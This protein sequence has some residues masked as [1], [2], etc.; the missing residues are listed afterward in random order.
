[1]R[2]AVHWLQ[3]FFTTPLPSEVLLVE[4]L[5]ET[6]TEAVL[7]TDTNPD[8]LWHDTVIVAEIIQAEQHP[9]ADSLRVCRVN[10]G[11]EEKQIVCGAPN[12]RAGIQV[13]LA[14]VGSVLPGNF[15]I[16]KSKIRGVESQGMLC[17]AKE[18]RLGEDQD[19]IVELQGNIPLGT[20]VAEHLQL[21]ETVIECEITA[22]RGDCFS[23]LGIARE[24]AAKHSLPLTVPQAQAHMPSSQSVVEVQVQ[25]PAACPLYTAT[26]ID[27]INIRAPTPKW[28]ARILQAS[29]IALHN[30]AVDIT[31]YVMLESGQPLHAFSGEIINGHIEVRFAKRNETVTLLNNT[32]YKLNANT[33]VIAD[34]TSVVGLAGIMGSLGSGCHDAT[35]RVILESALFMPE[36][37]AGVARQYGLHTDASMRFERGVDPQSVTKAAQRAV[38]LLLE[39]AGGKAGLLISTESKAHM[40]ASKPITVDIHY[41]NSLLGTNLSISTMVEFLRRLGFVCQQTDTTITA[42]PP[43]HRWDIQL[44][45]DIAEEVGRL[46]GLNA[47]DSQTVGVPATLAVPNASNLDGHDLRTQ[48]HDFIAHE[49][50]ETINYSFL[51]PHFTKPFSDTAPVLLQNPIAEN[52]AAMRTS[53]LPSLLK[54][55][56]SNRTR[57]FQKELRLFESAMVYRGTLD[58]LKQ[59]HTTAGV[60]AVGSLHDWRSNKSCDFFWMK[61]YIRSLLSLL[62]IKTVQWAQETNNHWHPTQSARI[63]IGQMHIGSIGIM[64]PSITALFDVQET[65]FAFEIDL[66]AV[67][68]IHNKQRTTRY[69]PVSH[70]PISWRDFAFIVPSD[71]DFA[72]LQ[73]HIKKHA[74]EAMHTIT[75]FDVY[76]GAPLLAN[77]KSMAIRI[78][79]QDSNRTL[80]EDDIVQWADAVVVAAAQIGA[81]L[82]DG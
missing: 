79:W 13:A 34:K 60:I 16:K 82:R 69:K 28:M 5:C 45:V 30:I 17:S 19:G 81:K 77:E 20:L 27:D 25:E 26:V 14:Q 35:T 11:T 72:Q 9:N 24:L 63:Q 36:A 49:F 59:L 1:M 10:T 32:Q 67:R 41:V 31:N 66:D 71:V 64:H 53:I 78:E 2:L 6:G 7:L 3:Q 57:G 74:G 23:A 37:L 80:T 46:Y 44:P 39:Y 21:R 52:Q 18:L 75:L 76:T 42:T 73:S 22:N 12:A 43:S 47:I 33:L 51:E 40:P 50:Y 8:T 56:H 68:K 4:S 29:G 61:Q 70:T 55:I 38:A 65:V 58:T 54:N 48:A 15:T 62:G